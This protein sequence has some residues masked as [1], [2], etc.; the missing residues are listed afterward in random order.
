MPSPTRDDEVFERRRAIQ[1]IE[2]LPTIPIMLQKIIAISSDPNTSAQDLER[3][4]IK[5]QSIAAAIL[6]LANSAYYGYARTVDDIGRA[7]VIIGFKTAVSVAISVSVL[8]SLTQIIQSDEFDCTEFWKHSIASG[9]AGQ[10]FAREMDPAIRDGLSRAYIVGLLHDIGKIVLAYLD[11]VHFN[12]AVFEARALQKPLFECEERIF[13]FDHQTA[14]G[15]LAE[16]WH[17]PEGIVAAVRYHHIPHSGIDKCPE[18]LLPDV[19]VAHTANYIVH[20]V[21]IGTSGDVVPQELHP[22]VGSKFAISTE[23]FNHIYS[24]LEEQREIINV[25]LEAI[26]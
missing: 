18:H 21:H 16:R 25:F 8:R 24:K 2:L 13:G 3:T 19:L 9:E 14:G 17:L 12:D 11:D 15:W 6:K 1:K 23:T 4:I 26:L 22:L 10:L 20:S 5:D 7:I